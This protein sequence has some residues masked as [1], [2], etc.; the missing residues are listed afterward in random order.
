MTEKSRSCAM[1]RMATDTDALLTV[2][3]QNPKKKSVCVTR[4]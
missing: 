3:V 4:Q 2:E 1:G